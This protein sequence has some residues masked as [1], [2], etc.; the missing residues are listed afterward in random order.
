MAI[1]EKLKLACYEY[2]IDLNWSQA[3]QRAGYKK[4]TAESSGNKYFVKP[5]VEALIN[6]LMAQRIKR[7]ERDADDVLEE[8]ENIAFSNVMDVFDYAIE[9]ENSPDAIKTL[10]L[11]DLSTL[12]HSVT[13][14]IREIKVTPISNLG[15]N[16]IEFKLHNKLAALEALGRHFQLFDKASSQGVEFHM[17]IDLGEPDDT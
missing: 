15:A 2:L 13:A 5:D 11:K 7:I 1:S 4:S 16:K 8:L 17:N 9:D 3:M 6:E 10:A 14:A 12:P